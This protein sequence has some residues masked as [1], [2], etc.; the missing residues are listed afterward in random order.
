MSGCHINPAVTI[1]L[2]VTGDISIL[3]SIFYIAVQCAGA[4]AGAAFIKVRILWYMMELR[5]YFDNIK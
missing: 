1:G 2:L 5:I 4:I 3:K